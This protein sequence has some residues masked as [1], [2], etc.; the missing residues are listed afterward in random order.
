MENKIQSLLSRRLLRTLLGA[1]EDMLGKNLSRLI[2][3]ED[4]HT[5]M[6]SPGRFFVGAEMK[7]I[8]AHCLMH[9]DIEPATKLPTQMWFGTVYIPSDAPFRVRRRSNP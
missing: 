2:L 1:W 9:Y 7:L 6:L 8:L 5:V 4:A 3:N